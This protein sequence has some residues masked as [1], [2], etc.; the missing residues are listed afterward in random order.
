M[1]RDLE[2][3]RPHPGYEASDA[4][5]KPIL[6]FLVGLAV[7]I[8]VA[9]GAMAL[10]FNILESRLG[11]ADQEISPLIDTRQIPFGPR[12]QVEPARELS[13]VLEWE[14]RMLNSYGWVDEDT[15]VF[16]IP[17]GRAMEI[18]AETGLPARAPRETGREEE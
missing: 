17:I 15:G 13:E 3:D 14:E 9:L 4:D 6:G 11:R 2:K 5:V 18:L 16:R 8:V 12:L 10:L 7:L 1:G